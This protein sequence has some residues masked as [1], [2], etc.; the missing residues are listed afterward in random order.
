MPQKIGYQV[1]IWRKVVV[2]GGGYVYGNVNVEGGALSIGL[3]IYKGF[4]DLADRFSRI[5][6]LQFS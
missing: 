1:F 4:L 6:S 3:E 5:D 2:V